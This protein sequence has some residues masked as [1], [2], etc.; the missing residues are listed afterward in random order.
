MS[1]D[2][3]DMRERI[4]ALFKRHHISPESLKKRYILERIEEVFHIVTSDDRQKALQIKKEAFSLIEAIEVEA[5]SHSR[6]LPGIYPR[7]WKLKKEG[8]RLAIAT[9]NCEKA[10]EAVIG[11]A[12]TFFDIILTRE[13]SPAYK[14]KRES[15]LPI[16][17]SFSLPT[18][19]VFMIGDHPLDI[20]TAHAARLPAIGVL[21]GTGSK[22]ALKKAGAIAVVKHANHAIDFLLKKHFRSLS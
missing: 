16:L 10:I 12:K 18:H 19:R 9:R 4:N 8:M 21:T 13:N 1:I 5:A 17:R 7:L 3:V 15:L 2:F 14:P 6:L 22:E 20:L 11:K